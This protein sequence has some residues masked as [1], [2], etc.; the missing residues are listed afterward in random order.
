MSDRTATK[1]MPKKRSKRYQQAA[2][3]VE[4]G[5]KY[6]LA[7]AAA[8]LKLFLGIDGSR[9]HRTDMREQQA[10]ALSIKP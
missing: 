9:I 1:T 7:E 4:E 10:R 5:K 8:L 6:S 2:A 3:L